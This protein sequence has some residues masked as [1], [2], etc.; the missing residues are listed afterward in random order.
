M[1]ESTGM[2]MRKYIPERKPKPAKWLALSETRRL[3]LVEKAHNDVDTGL[4]PSSKLAHAAM[5]V[6]VENQLALEVPEVVS[7]FE[8]LRKEGLDRHDCIHAVASVLIEHL[9]D[10]EIPDM[11]RCYAELEALTAKG[12][13]KRYSEI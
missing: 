13:I 9:F 7:A 11:A 8:R 10:N 1:N 2:L 12:W 5:H 4:E 3:A 6:A